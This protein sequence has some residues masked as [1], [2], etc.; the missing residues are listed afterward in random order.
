MASEPERR[1]FTRISAAFEIDLRT[2][3]GS[4]LRGQLVNASLQGLRLICER[5][6]PVGSLCRIALHPGARESSPPI[7]ARGSVVRAEEGM[8]TLRLHEI[9]YEAFER[10]RAFLLRHASDPALVDD[11]LSERLGFQPGD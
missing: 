6:L 3:D 7:E 10:L 5:A 1:A 11:E 9:P 2:A 8:L 4:E